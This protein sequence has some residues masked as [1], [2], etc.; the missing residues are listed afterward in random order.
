MWKDNH[1]AQ[2]SKTSPKL[3][4]AGEAGAERHKE[5]HRSNTDLIVQRHNNVIWCAMYRSTV[6]K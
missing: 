3:S 2:T 1:N 5:V 4:S 6:T